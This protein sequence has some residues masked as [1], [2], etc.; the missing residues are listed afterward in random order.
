[1]GRTRLESTRPTFIY[2]HEMETEQKSTERKAK[3][4]RE[5][6]VKD[7]IRMLGVMNGKE[8][9]EHKETWR[10]IVEAEMGL[11]GLE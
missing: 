4:R 2:H 11:N 6:R 7:D 3:Q 9:A 1:M 5:D 10:D 8:L